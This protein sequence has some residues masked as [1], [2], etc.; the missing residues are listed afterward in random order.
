M[1]KQLLL[2]EFRICSSVQTFHPQFSC[3][4]KVLVSA[5]VSSLVFWLQLFNHKLLNLVLHLRSEPALHIYLLSILKPMSFHVRDRQLTRQSTGLAFLTRYVL[6]VLLN[7]H[8]CKTQTGYLLLEDSQY[9]CQSSA[10]Y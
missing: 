3:G 5:G 1:E 4:L 9:C 8:L 7:L 2:E 6:Q 10:E